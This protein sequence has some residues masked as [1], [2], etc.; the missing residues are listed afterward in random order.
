MGPG[1]SQEDVEEKGTGSYIW[2]DHF[3]SE[4]VDRETG[5]PLPYG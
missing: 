5:E 4:V 1:V 2:E 3:F